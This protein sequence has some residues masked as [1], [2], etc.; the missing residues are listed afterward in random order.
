MIIDLILDR[1]DGQ[2]YRAE[3]FYRET[4]GYVAGFNGF[5]G[6]ILDAMDGG[7]EQDVKNALNK[8]I[9]EGEYNPKISDYIN[10]VNWLS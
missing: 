3:N 8:Y 6:D 5:G 9:T 2:A 7:T 4:S 1:K 10:S